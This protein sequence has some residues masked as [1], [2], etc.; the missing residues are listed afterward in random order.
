VVVDEA[1][2]S[3]A[4]VRETDISTI[5]SRRRPWVSLGEV[6]RSLEPGM[7]LS[8]GLTG[9]EVLAAVRATPAT[10]Y[11]VIG[12]DGVSK[13]VLATAD[14]ARVLGLRHSRN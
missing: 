10:E 6:S 5:E 8:E 3:R 4:I 12:Q 13:G 14:L 11:L 7:I 9:A 1:G 2:R